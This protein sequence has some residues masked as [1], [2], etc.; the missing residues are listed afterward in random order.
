MEVDE[1]SV[2]SSIAATETPR[3]VMIH[4]EIQREGEAN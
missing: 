1:R 2:T 3:Y 4:V